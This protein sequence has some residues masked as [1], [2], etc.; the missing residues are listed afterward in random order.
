MPCR[1]VRTPVFTFS[2]TYFSIAATAIISLPSSARIRSPTS[3]ARATIGASTAHKPPRGSPPRAWCSLLGLVELLAA[4]TAA[5][6][7]LLAVRRYVDWDAKIGPASLDDRQPARRPQP[8]RARTSAVASMI[9]CRCVHERA[10]RA[11]YETG[12]RGIAVRSRCSPSRRRDGSADD[13]VAADARSSSGGNALAAALPP[14]APAGPPALRAAP[15]APVS[16]RSSRADGSGLIRRRRRIR[17]LR[18][19]DAVAKDAV[20]VLLPGAAIDR[21]AISSLLV[22]ACRC[23]PRRWRS[24]AQTSS[25]RVR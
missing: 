17:L 10:I 12:E 8:R 9:C 22:D 3:F 2:S 15:A 4:D 6:D 20:A 14:A 18:G 7:R 5:A 11:L 1:L 24:R 19:A 23:C 21:N 13:A 25:V 16:R